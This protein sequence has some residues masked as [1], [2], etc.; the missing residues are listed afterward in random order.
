MQRK[1]FEIIK[2]DIEATGQ[3]MIVYSVFVKYLRKIR[4]T[5]KQCMSTL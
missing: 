4:N 2:V 5:T 3:L 1:L